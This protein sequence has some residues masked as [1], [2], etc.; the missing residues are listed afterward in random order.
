[1][2]SRLAVEKYD[3]F[4]YHF[5]DEENFVNFQFWYFPKRK[6]KIKE[7]WIS[8]DECSGA[9]SR[10][11]VDFLFLLSSILYVRKS[12]I[13]ENFRWIYMFWDVLTTISP[14]FLNVCLSVCMYVFKHCGHCISRT[15]AQKLMKFYIQ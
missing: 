8:K 3:M 1:M 14:F 4:D 10:I 6:R 7:G 5:L 9:I 2:V 11:L 15:N 13:L 12:W